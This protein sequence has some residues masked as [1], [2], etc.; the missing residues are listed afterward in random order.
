MCGLASQLTRSAYFLARLRSKEDLT[1]LGFADYPQ[2]DATRV[3]YR[4]N[5]PDFFSP[6]GFCAT[7]SYE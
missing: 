4:D 7:V 5:N 6:P 2:V 1:A 3:N